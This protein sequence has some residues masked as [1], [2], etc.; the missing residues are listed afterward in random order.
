MNQIF[1]ITVYFQLR[2]NW[3]GTFPYCCF[4]M[5]RESRKKCRITFD[6]QKK[7]NNKKNS[8][9]KQITYKHCSLKRFILLFILRNNKEIS[10]FSIRRQILTSMYIH[11]ISWICIWYEISKQMTLTFRTCC[12]V[13]YLF[14]S[15]QCQNVCSLFYISFVFLWRI[16]SIGEFSAE[17]LIFLLIDCIPLLQVID[18]RLS[19]EWLFTICIFLINMV[20]CCIMPN[21]I[22]LNSQA[23]QKRRLVVLNIKYLLLSN[24]YNDVASDR[25]LFEFL[26]FFCEKYQN[27]KKFLSK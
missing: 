21:G 3:N 7:K 6:Q 8:L 20:R 12:C 17:N 2:F 18:L 11:L 25:F 23:S 27:K 4:F 5:F 10:L 24:Y 13:H 14:R 16:C 26:F 22:A 9:T 19:P 1:S 15:C